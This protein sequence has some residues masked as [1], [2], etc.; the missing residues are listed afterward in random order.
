M[1]SFP[2]NILQQ[3]QTYQ[4]AGLAFLENSSCM[5]YTSNNKFRNFDQMIANLGDT[6]TFDLPPR[7]TTGNTLVVTFQSAQQR[8]AN[9]TVQGQA[10][11]SFT[12]TDQ[13]FIFN[14][15]E[16]MERFGE[17]AIKELGSQIEADVSTVA[18]T[19]TFRY[20]GT[21]SVPITTFGQLAQMIANYKMF[22][23]AQNKLKVYLPMTA[24]PQIVNSG[25]NQ[26][27]IDRNKDMAFSW[28]V[29]SWQGVEYYQSNLLPIHVSGDTG[30]LQQTLTVIST[31]DPT[32]QDITQ[33]TLSGASANDVNA[34]KA[35]DLFTY[36]DGVSGQ[37]NLRFLTFI[38]HK[39][40]P[41]QV[42]IAAAADAASDSSGNVTIT[43]L[44][45]LSSAAG[46]NQNI[47]NNIQP[48]MQIL[49]VQNHTCGLVVGGEAL[50]LGMPRLPNQTPFPTSNH[51]DEDTGVSIRQYFGTLFGQNQQGMVYDAIWGKT[52]VPEYAMRLV[53]PA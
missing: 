27:V 39:L 44:N 38:G 42:Q 37:P 6:V 47:N 35:G 28:M 51:V 14:V 31:N 2:N 30:N 8:V 17:A 50:F 18:E 29:G 46:Q 34:V 7:F 33:I 53:F 23:A 43:L 10:N 12:F 21:P 22:G 40:T 49:G 48:G 45:P 24:V 13:Q 19:S 11:T 26:F 52:L 1:S 5:V 20:F 36:Q 16:Y 25:L 32:G 9:L 15:R 41:L 3:V 4:M